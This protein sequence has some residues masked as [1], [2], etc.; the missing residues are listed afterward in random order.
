[1]V[2]VGL[3]KHTRISNRERQQQKLVEKLHSDVIT[4]R[5][6]VLVSQSRPSPPRA[7]A[8][9]RYSS[10]GQGKHYLSE[11]ARIKIV[12]L[13]D[14]GMNQRKIAAIVGCCQKTISNTLRS[15]QKYHNVRTRPKGGRPRSIPARELGWLRAAILKRNIKPRATPNACIQWLAE[16]CGLQ[17][18]LSTLYRALKR[19]GL[20]RFVVRSKPALTA[21]AV[22]KRKELAKVWATWSPLTLARTVFSDEAGVGKYPH[23]GKEVVFDKRG[24]PFHRGRVHPELPM[25]SLRVNVWAAITNRG[26]LASNTYEGTMN[27]DRYLK[28]LRYQLVPAAKMRFGSRRSWRFQQD[29]ARYHLE[30]R[31]KNMM[32]GPSWK[33]IHVLDWPPYSPDLNIIENFWPRL[34]ERV[35][36]FKP[37]NKEQLKNAIKEAISEMN[38]EEPQT[39]YFHNLFSSFPTRCKETVAAEGFSVDH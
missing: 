34:R 21:A 2:V 10:Q 31:V 18:K 24:M 25:S 27:S 13:H 30:R 23:H 39:H 26:V 35:A 32:R 15:F 17:I 6:F 11:A 8:T 16:H 36:A 28:I 12:R 14:Q 29:N 37:S 38:K 4:L 5:K 19:I 33:K 3:S 22:E 1:M 7:A 20:Q 9:M